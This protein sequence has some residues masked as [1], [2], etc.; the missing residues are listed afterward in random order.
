VAVTARCQLEL[1]ENP[2]WLDSVTD[3]S[4][5]SDLLPMCPEYT[6]ASWL[7]RLDS[8]TLA[9]SEARRGVS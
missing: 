1:I 9:P 5:P 2:V 6:E 8:S 4:G 3:V 7:L